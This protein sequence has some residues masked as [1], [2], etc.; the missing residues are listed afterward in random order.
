M[1]HNHSN[2][3]GKNEKVH[4]KEGERMYSQQGKKR[5]RREKWSCE[6]RDKQGPKD[7]KNY[8]TLV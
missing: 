8:S 3:E 7:K 2:V 4:R 5:E 1:N 6:R